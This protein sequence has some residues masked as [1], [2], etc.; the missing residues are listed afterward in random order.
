LG[1]D[2]SGAKF[3]YFPQLLDQCIRIYR[4]TSEPKSWIERDLEYAER[5]GEK[6]NKY[7]KS[8]KVILTMFIAEM[9]H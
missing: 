7:T 3:F 8:G 2:R 6:V 1:Q 4:Q 9:E 5:L